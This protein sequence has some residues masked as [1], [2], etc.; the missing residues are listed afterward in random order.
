MLTHQ[1]LVDQV[2]AFKRAQSDMGEAGREL[3]IS[4]SRL[5]FIA[6]SEA[7]RRNKIEAAYRY[8]SRFDNVFT[9]PGIV[10]G[11]MIRPLP[12]SQTIE[13]LAE[14]LLICTPAEMIDKIAPYQELGVDRLILS[15][16]FETGAQETLDCIQRF[17]EEVMPHFTGRHGEE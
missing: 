17:A 1:L 8:Y 11:G 15:V 4:L 7:D 9:G 2:N 16:N 12:R 14:S 3:T 5:A 13:E 6:T 10:E